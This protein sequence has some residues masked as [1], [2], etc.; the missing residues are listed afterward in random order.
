MIMREIGK[1][2][3]L[4]GKHAMAIDIYDEIISRSENDWEA[5]HEKGTCCMN[6][7]NYDI[8]YE[9]FEK[10]LSLCNNEQT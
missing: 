10:A 9:C 5:W 8:A 1:S 4:L 6:M 3:S 7:K 2:M